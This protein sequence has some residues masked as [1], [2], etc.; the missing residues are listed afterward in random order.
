MSFIVE[1]R[2]SAETFVLA[3]T[4]E[5]YPDTR[6]EF[7]RF[8]PRT[9][10][11]NISYLWAGDNGPDLRPFQQAAASDPGVEDLQLVDDLD[12]GA[13]FRVQWTE[14]DDRNRITDAWTNSDETLVQAVGQDDEW[15]LKIR[16]DDR[17]SITD[18]QSYADEHDLDFD[19]LRLYDVEA[20]KLGQY[21][22]TTRQR[23]ALVVALE[24]GYFDVPRR[25]ELS[26]VA[27]ELGL[28]IN[29]VS[30]R[31]RRGEGNLFRSA[32]TVPRPPH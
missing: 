11:E 28:S 8:I 1:L 19:L 7:E 26:D 3:Q 29:A 32:L 23:D 30:E 4:M 10:S 16:F 17:E 12:G 20:P 6:L 15:F 31:I 24:M 13:L 2:I 14:S 25:C 5:A 18:F 22:L 27:D 9:F 21:D